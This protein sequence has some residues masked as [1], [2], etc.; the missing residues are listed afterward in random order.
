[1]NSENIRNVDFDIVRRGYN[2]VD[3]DDYLQKV[4]AYV[5]EL[6]LERDNL[7][8]E[9]DA[10][11]E[12]KSST[13]SKMLVLAQKVEEYRGEEDTLKTALINAQRMGETVVHEAKQ[14]AD[15]LVREANG[16]AQLLREQAEEEIARERLTL[17][18]L[19]AEVTRF[20]ATI[21]N[22][23]KQ[24]IE[25]LSALDEPVSQIDEIMEEHNWGP[26]SSPEPE[27]EPKAPDVQN[28]G[29][30]EPEIPDNKMEAAQAAGIETEPP[31]P[32]E[33]PVVNLFE[34]VPIEPDHP[35]Q[36]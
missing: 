34:G 18:K 1:M 17:E 26:L 12:A 33:A 24:H 3:V 16:T 14:K 29:G 35:A 15:A 4:A 25:S 9:R 27:E 6:T 8:G 21:L 22:L 30:A 32:E 20:K 31:E 13:E 2:K 11:L 36:E 19:Q 5:D 10:A 28:F 7:I 23:Y